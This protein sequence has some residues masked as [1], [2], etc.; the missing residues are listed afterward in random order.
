M[1]K[2][3]TRRSSQPMTLPT[4]VAQVPPLDISKALHE[5]FEVAISGA[6]HLAA[7]K[8]VAQAAESHPVI[9][10]ASPAFFR[11][12][13]H[14][15][16]ECAQ[17]SAAR[18]FDKEHNVGIP[19]LLKQARNRREEFSSRTDSEFDEAIESAERACTAKALVP[20]KHRR[21]RW[22][23]HL[24]KKTIRDPKQFEIDAKMTCSELEDLFDSAR[25]ILN[26]MSNLRGEA[27]FLIL[28][29]DYNDLSHTL[30]LVA[31]GVQ[32]NAQELE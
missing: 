32:A 17:M 20:L 19:W 10:N 26:A 15:H 5:L 7:A 21:D 1:R 9:M 24:D 23:T 16:L 22:L 29:E 28:G 30:D 11:L 4:N 14:A 13:T 18:L 12:T 25:D 2:L 6:A 27:G 31:K 8:S 3:V